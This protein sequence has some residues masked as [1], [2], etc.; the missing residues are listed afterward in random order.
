MIRNLYRLNQIPLLQVIASLCIL[1]C[2]FFALYAVVSFIH[3][4]IGDWYFYASGISVLI[5]MRMAKNA[6]LESELWPDKK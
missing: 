2:S 6:P 3:E 5:L 1:A 4:Y